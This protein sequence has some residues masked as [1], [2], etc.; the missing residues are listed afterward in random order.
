MPKE[1]RSFKTAQL[2]LQ[3]VKVKQ[4]INHG[5]TIVKF[6]PHLKQ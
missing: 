4:F 1:K 6:T 3:K 5:F 2:G